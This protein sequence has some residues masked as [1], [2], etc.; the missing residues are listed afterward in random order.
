MSLE[1]IDQRRHRRRLTPDEL[2]LWSGITRSIAP[3]KRK[4]PAPH[5]HGT[6]APGESMPPPAGRRAEPAPPRHPAPNPTTRPAVRPALAVG[7]LD[8]RQKQRLARGSETI[9][10]R[11]DLHGRTQSE[12]HAALLAFLRGA[13]ADGARFVLVITGKGGV[14]GAV[15][16][17]ERGVLKRQ[18]P[19]WL[20]LPEFRL[21]VLAVEDAHVAHGGEGALY[22]R[23]RRA[24]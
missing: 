6:T 20:R 13:Q 18:V 9:D 24:R 22:V 14:A 16:S 5:R 10:G 21:L 7:G 15:S 11:I 3:L 2:K 19:Q 4:P 8:R 1:R 12:A 23:L 17:S